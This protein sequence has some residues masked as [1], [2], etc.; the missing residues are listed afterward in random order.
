MWCGGSARVGQTGLE[1]ET[2]SKIVQ[3]QSMKVLGLAKQAWRLKLL[4]IWLC[5]R[6]CEMHQAHVTFVQRT[7]PWERG[8]RI[9]VS[10]EQDQQE[11]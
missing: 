3:V 11:F 10:S 1:V 7:R 8:S 2:A 4:L 6:I 5:R 9:I